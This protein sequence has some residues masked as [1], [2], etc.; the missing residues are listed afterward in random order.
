M[1]SIA[2][3]TFKYDQIED[4]ILMVGNLNNNQQRVDF[5]LTRK[6]VLRL[7]NGVEELF[8][9]TAGAKFAVPAAHKSQMMQFDHDQA[10]TQLVLDH[11][12]QEVIS[13]EGGLLVR[14]DISYKQERYQLLFYTGE[15]DP[16]AVSILTYDELHQILH[17]IHKGALTLDWGV[18]SVLFQ[19]SSSSQT[20]Q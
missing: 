3:F 19:S 2:A 18:K 7:L 6:L 14:L 13:E 11:E 8:E 17:L 1:L 9:K 12:N 15:A 20:L 5:W 16:V 10:Q 4:R